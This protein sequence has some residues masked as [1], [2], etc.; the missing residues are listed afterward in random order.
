MTVVIVMRQRNTRYPLSRSGSVD[1][2][3]Y[4]LVSPAEDEDGPPPYCCSWRFPPHLSR[5]PSRQLLQRGFLRPSRV[6]TAL[7]FVL[8]G[9]CRRSVMSLSHLARLVP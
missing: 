7:P 3:C 4:G 8:R 6:W 2:V 1:C 5:R 9:N